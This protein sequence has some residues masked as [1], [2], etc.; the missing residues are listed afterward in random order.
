MASD[1]L[2]V[3][4]KKGCLGTW[5]IVKVGACKEAIVLGMFMKCESF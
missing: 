1:V 2:E 4:L 3:L 5:L